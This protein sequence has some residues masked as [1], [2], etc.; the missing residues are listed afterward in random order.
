MAHLDAG[1]SIPAPAAAASHSSDPQVLPAAVEAASASS[2]VVFPHAPGAAAC[3]AS[4]SAN[5]SSVPCLRPIDAREDPPVIDSFE[6]RMLFPNLA[7]SLT[8]LIALGSRRANQ[9]D[10]IQQMGFTHI[11]Q[12]SDQPPPTSGA[13]THRDDTR[14]YLQMQ[15]D[16]E[17]NISAGDVLPS[18]LT[19][20]RSLDAAA[21]HR[22][23][24]HCEAGVS[25]SASLV[26]AFF[27]LDRG[28][29]FDAALAFVRERRPC[30]QPNEGFQRQLRM[31]A[32]DKNQGRAPL[33]AAGVST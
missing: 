15:D 10:F 6:Q 12:I 3:A 25:R 8:T 29:D 4:E 31:L 26:I 20:V 17:Q 24:V 32:T 30:V 23:L 19:F 1:F 5:S 28:M 9:P 11:V 16:E 18:F 33:S 21:G 14:L 7:D 27:I 13:C 2:C 22:L